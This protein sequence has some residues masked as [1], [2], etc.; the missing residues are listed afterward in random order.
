MN[1]LIVALD[2]PSAE[3]ALSMAAVLREAVGAF[4][5]GLG[6]LM[7]P[8]PL[9]TTAVASLER[10]VFVDAKLHDIPSVVAT[11]AEQLGKLG[12]RWVTAHASG[13]AEVL[14]AAVEGLRSGA[15][16][17]EVGILGVTVMT[18]TAEATLRSVGVHDSVGKQTARLAKLAAR[19]GCE[20]VICSGDQLRVVADAAPDLARVVPGIRPAG[21][22]A[23][24][25][26]HITSP[27]EAMARGADHIV[28]GRPII[29]ASDPAEAANAIL[30]EAALG[31]ERRL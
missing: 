14:Q 24:D 26:V 31:R 12:A 11:A 17:R 25:Q 22:D 27:T 21:A 16:G 7:G 4:K 29:G 8:G 6:L 28:V 15:R 10:P 3:E 20:G 18:A 5:I 1:P 9:V 30:N 13:G 23:A 19:A 2:L